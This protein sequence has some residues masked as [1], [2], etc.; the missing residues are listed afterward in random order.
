MS[1]RGSKLR[2]FM[3]TAMKNGWPRRRTVVDDEDERQS[4]DDN[5]DMLVIDIDIA[6]D[7]DDPMSYLNK[8]KTQIDGNNV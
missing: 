7:E 8:L 6:K 3:R 1:R 2:S 4:I 5:E